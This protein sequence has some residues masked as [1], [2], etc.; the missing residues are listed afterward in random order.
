MAATT[1]AAHTAVDEAAPSGAFL[2]TPSAVRGTL[3]GPDGPHPPAGDKRYW[4]VIS[5]ACPWANRTLAVRSVRGLEGAV[6]VAVIHPTWQRTRPVD[7]SDTHTGWVFC[8]PHPPALATSAGHGSVSVPGLTGPPPGAEGC[9]SVRDL[10]ERSGG[11]AAAAGKFSVP[12][13]WDAAAGSIVNNESADICRILGT[14]GG[15]DPWARPPPGAVADLYP[16]H[17]QARVEAANAWVYHSVNDGAY[18]CGFARTQ[19]AY[20]AAAGDLLAGLRRA[21]R[22]LSTSRFLTGPAFTEADVRLVQTLVRYD[23]VYVLYF[24]AAAFGFIRDSPVLAAYVRDVL[25]QPGMGPGAT[26][27]LD[28]IKAHYFTSHPTLNAYGIIPVGPVPDAG[29]CVWWEEGVEEAVAARAGLTG[30]GEDA[31]GA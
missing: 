29:G 30:E 14:G 25:D 12:L 2:R 13:L 16:Q 22:V 3:T 4:L 27:R 15:L 8:P 10:Y 28:H 24:K 19:A 31:D 26:V 21:E 6:G 7:E 5:W 20:E 23:P 9:A 1:P 11:P 18:R 17:L